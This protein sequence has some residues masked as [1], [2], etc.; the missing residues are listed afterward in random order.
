MT[1]RRA[2]AARR[3]RPARLPRRRVSAV[4]LVVTAQGLEARAMA[5]GLLMDAT[6]NRYRRECW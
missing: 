4:G 6:T 2:R 3:R 5:S 1:A